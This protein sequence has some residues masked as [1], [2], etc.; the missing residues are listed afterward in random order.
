[1]MDEGWLRRLNEAC[2]AAL[3]LARDP[4]VDVD[5]QLIADL[6]TLC[7]RVEQRLNELRT[8]RRAS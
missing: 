2:H 8:A 7:L 4:G 1:M 3:K 5:R 6:E